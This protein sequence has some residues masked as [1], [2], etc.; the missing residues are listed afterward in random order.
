MNS[1][2]WSLENGDFNG[3]FSFVRD[4]LE[5]IW[6]GRDIFRG[7]KRRFLE[8]GEVIG[9]EV[10]DDKKF[11]FYRIFFLGESL[12]GKDGIF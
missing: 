8:K 9:R 11:F 2:F 5:F 3:K 10:I 6:V 12:F 4:I 7:K 1:S